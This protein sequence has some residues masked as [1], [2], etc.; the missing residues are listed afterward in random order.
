MVSVLASQLAKEGHD[1]SVIKYFNTENDYLI[2]ERVKV[3]CISNGSESA[4]K[5][6]SFSL[7]VKK[8]RNAIKQIRPRYIVP[9][10]PHV[11]A[12]VFLA[13]FGLRFKAIQTIRVA[14]AIAPTSSVQRKIRDCLVGIS[15]A[16]FVQTLSQKSYFPSC[17]QHKIYVLP[18]PVSETMFDAKLIYPKSITNIISVGR[19]SAQ[20]NF[21]MLIEAIAAIN[22]KGYCIQLSIYGDG[23]LRDVLQKKIEDLNCGDF[24]YLCGRTTNMTETLCQ[25]HLFILSSNFEGLPNALM[26]AMSVGLPCISTDC[27]TGPSDLIQNGRG[28]LVPVDN[29]QAMVDAI[30]QMINYPEIATQMGLRAREYMKEN[31][32]PEIIAKRFINDVILRKVQR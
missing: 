18:N 16:T 10:L 6:L 1:I 23:E 21:E 19:L 20:K 24:C 29:R 5:A 32:S 27:P 30:E 17:I 15:Y 14:P 25:N 4:Y 26:E 12:H 31:Y 11:A 8:I 3:T 7:K 9:F 22:R 2:D 28:I 13:G